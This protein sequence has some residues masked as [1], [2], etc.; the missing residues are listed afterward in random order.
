MGKTAYHNIK[1]REVFTL[2]SNE[3]LGFYITFS[4]F[5]ASMINVLHWLVRG[6]S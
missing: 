4:Q 1:R 3:N 5:L 2:T 6:T